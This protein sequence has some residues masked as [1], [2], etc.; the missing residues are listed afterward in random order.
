MPADDFDF[1]RDRWLVDNVQYRD[2]SET[3]FPGEHSGI[4]KHMGGLVN[5][6]VSTFFASDS[7]DAFRGMSLRLLDPATDE[8]SIYWINDRTVQL[9]SPVSGSF[10]DGT[11]TFTASEE[12][13]RRR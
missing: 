10:A 5:T 1:L 6:D 7:D 8:W 4:V 13:A 3:R 2:G 11:G 9:S 12:R